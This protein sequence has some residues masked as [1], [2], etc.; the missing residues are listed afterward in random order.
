[1]EKFKNELP[2]RKQR[3]IFGSYVSFAASGGEYNP[4]RFNNLVRNSVSIQASGS[5]HCPLIIM[6]AGSL[7]IELLVSRPGTSG[8]SG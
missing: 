3:G 6:P 8:V 2:R 5:W 1:M 7:S 4:K